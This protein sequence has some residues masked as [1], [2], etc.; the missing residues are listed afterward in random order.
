MTKK[1]SNY[2]NHEEYQVGKPHDENNHHN[3]KSHKKHNHHGSHSHSAN[4]KT[5]AFCLVVTFLFSLIEGIGGYLTHSVTL[6]SDAVHML[7]DAA[8][9]LIAYIAN[10]ISKKPATTNLTFGYGKAEALGALINCVFT[11][12]LTTGLLIEAITRFFDPVEVHGNGLFIIAGVGLLVNGFIAYILTKNSHSLNM[13]AALIH[14]LGDIVA[15]GI[16][17]V[18]GLLIMYTGKN[19]IDPILSLIVVFILIVSNY[20][21]IKKS[22][23]VLMAG[24]PEYIDYENVGQDLE[25]IDGV[26]G[27]HDLHI[28]YLT[29]NTAALSAHIIAKSPISWEDTL[30]ACQKILKEKHNIE[31]VTL[32][33]EFNHNP[34]MAYCEVR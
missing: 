30:L 8:G 12:V 19:I 13:K 31:H 7:T 21:L 17:I 33:H 26:V 5:L 16:A 23:I 32:Q 9:L 10:A 6:K 2:L 22:S 14:T 1:Y 34:E 29:A 3:I 11:L 4:S 24:V 15:S 20:N 25:T 18:A 28:W 27:I